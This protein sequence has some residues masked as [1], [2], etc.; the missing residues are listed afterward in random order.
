MPL[1]HETEYN[2][3]TIIKNEMKIYKPWRKMEILFSVAAYKTLSRVNQD[4]EELLLLLL[5]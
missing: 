5:F 1:T 4:I 3:D 2:N